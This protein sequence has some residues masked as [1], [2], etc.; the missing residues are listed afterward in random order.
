MR[1]TRVYL[2]VVL[3]MGLTAIGHPAAAES[4]SI[5]GRVWLQPAF[6][7]ATG[8]DS[9]TAVVPTDVS[10]TGIPLI[11]SV[12]VSLPVTAEVGFENPVGFLFGGEVI[13]RRVGIEVNG[14]YVPRAAVAGGGLKVRGG[15][16]TE[17]ECD[18]L[19][20]FGIPVN[21]M[22]VIEEDIANLVVTLGVNYHFVDGGRWDIWA[23]PMA[24]W[25]AWGKYDLADARLELR[26][27]LEDLLHGSVDEFEL[28]DNPAIA[29]EDALS[30]GASAGV[31]Y[32]FTNSWSIVG[33]VRYFVGD[34]VELPDAS[35][36][37]G[38]MSFSMG[39]ARSFGH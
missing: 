38:V 28:S 32:E 20:A 25:T 9:V 17:Q 12:D 22:M 5:R 6:G 11:G 15:L 37:Y 29:P 31:S 19:E 33:N 34:D 8:D 14:I 1:T 16:L 7:L 27:S 10:V 24:V 21:D 23:G 18:T 2:A 30:F 35:G 3:L 13:F 26:Q 4:A 36:S 39:V